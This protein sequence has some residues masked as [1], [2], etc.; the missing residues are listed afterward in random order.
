MNSTAGLR[1]VAVIGAGIV[2]VCA[3][4]YLQRDGHRVTLVDPRGP[5]E[6]TSKGNA[7]VLA[8]ESCVPVATPGI[9]W[10]VPGMLADPLGPLA[11]RWAYLPRLA[12]WLTRFVLA[13]RPA[14]VEAISIALRAL[15]AD[16][17]EAYLPLVKSAGI[18][19]MIRRTGWLGVY[20]SE[21]KFAGA[22]ADLELQRRRGV[23][24]E[25][26]KPEEIRQFE[27]A[28]API[29]KHAVFYP[30]NAYVV[31]N[32]RLV[33]S[34]AEDFVRNG[35]TLLREAA[36]GFDIAD[37]R[38]THLRTDAGRHAIDA[39]VVAAGAWSKELTRQLGHRVPLD[40]ERGYHVML[41]DSGVAPRMPIYSGDHSFAVTPLE[42]GLRLAGTVELGGLDAAPNYARADM[43]LT[44]G[45]RMFPGLNE[46][47][48]TKWM[49]FR[50]SMPDSVPVISGSDRC[51]NA[52]F[53]FGHGHIGLTLGAQTGR[54]IGD[55]VA[56]RDPGVDMR[57]YRVDR[58]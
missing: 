16:S 18:E 3:A 28:L 47:G 12:P 48:A 14:R 24:M 11:I 32:F 1:H 34:L 56:G 26:L 45:R 42:H 30:E 50:P 37:G 31:N 52:F 39:V 41:P 35:G 51:R 22:R 38:A 20:E 5:G 9:V 57:S 19:E 29:Y 49:G 4:L 36:T 53:G 10:R 17:I 8:V 27:P 25:F 43:L 7:S 54:L 44:R 6:G 15:L 33:V 23:R 21:A 40:T 58:F 13:S 2:G 46:A 55:L